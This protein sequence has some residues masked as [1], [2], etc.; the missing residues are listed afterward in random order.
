MA[1]LSKTEAVYVTVIDDPN[2]TPEAKL[3]AAQSLD[4]LRNQRKHYRNHTRAK[5]I[6]GIGRKEA[7]SEAVERIIA[8]L[9]ESDRCTEFALNTWPTWPKEKRDLWLKVLELERT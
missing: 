1:R 8:E 4:K 5:A 3:A 9:P 6:L 7:K 2:T